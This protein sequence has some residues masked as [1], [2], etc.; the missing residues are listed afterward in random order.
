MSLT[1]IAD[2][3]A[4]PVATVTPGVLAFGTVNAG[5]SPTLSTTVRN[6]GNAPLV[7]GPADDHR[8]PRP[9]T[10]RSPALT[11]GTIAVAPTE[12]PDHRPVHAESTGAR[13]AT[14]S[15]PHNAAGSPQPSVSLTGTGRLDVHDLAA[16]ADSFGDRH[17]QHDQDASR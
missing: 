15:I 4:S 16:L 17:T 3:A 14:L 10:T 13:T 1:G 11:C 7:S 2:P 9:P 6:T 12:L 5:S 8:Y